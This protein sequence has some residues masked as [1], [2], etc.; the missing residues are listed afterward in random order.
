VSDQTTFCGECGRPVAPPLLELDELVLAELDREG[1]APSRRIARAV[2]R[3]IGDV[4]ETLH[5]LEAD[6]L[7]ERVQGSNSPRSRAW[8]IATSGNAPGTHEAAKPT[9]DGLAAAGTAVLLLGALTASGGWP[10]RVAIAG[11]LA[12]VFVALGSIAG[13]RAQ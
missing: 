10:R 3:R 6:G 2:R 9:S 11:L 4:L 13:A 1:S 7:V 5:R 8:S 12:L